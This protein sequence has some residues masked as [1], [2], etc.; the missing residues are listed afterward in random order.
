M[1]SMQVK[2]F[3]EPL[4]EMNETNPT[5][6][7]DEVLLSVLA[8]GVCHTDLHLWQGGY[9]LGGGKRLS[10]EE[11]GVNLPLTMG[12]ETVGR[13]VAI[14]EHVTKAKIGETY[15]IYPWLGCGICESCARGEENYCLKPNTIGINR[16]GGYADHVLVP[17]E[18]C[19]ISLRGLDPVMAA[20]LACSG[21]TCYSIL[22]KIGIE[23]LRHNLVLII[24]AG[25]LGLMCLKLLSGLNAKGAV[26]IE[27]NQ[28]RA[29][30][31]LEA[32]AK[33]VIDPNAD[34]VTKKINCAMGGLS[35]SVIDLVGNQETSSMA[36]DSLSKGGHL[37]SVGLFGGAA[38]W[39]LPILAMKAITIQGSYVGSLPELQELVDLVVDKNLDLIPTKTYHLS[40][41][42]DALTELEDGN[43]VGRLVLTP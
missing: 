10:L 36:F 38:N 2:D 21:L 31:A 42:G 39:P 17:S 41:A 29:K 7:E 25:G 27:P 23:K 4:V 15:L 22:K 11:R 20:P 3:G 13:V 28:Q 34:D 40:K 12:H 37:V 33:V 43:V 8:A 18:R 35:T 26:V 24:G 16:A 6:R 14:G 32:G 9:D 19:L 5:P 30:A 1:R